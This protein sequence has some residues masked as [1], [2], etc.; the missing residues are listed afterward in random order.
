L[1]CSYD[2]FLRGFRRVGLVTKASVA[3]NLIATAV[4]SGLVVA[5]G[6]RGIAWALVAQPFIVLIVAAIAG[7]DYGTYLRASSHAR[8]REAAIRVVRMGIVLTITGFITTGVQLAARV[9]VEH[10]TSLDD[11][12][13]F[14]AA[15]AISVLYLG[16]VL[17][18]MSLD[19]YPR[20]AEIGT[21]RVALRRMV[22]EQAR[23]SLLLAGPAVLGLL[24][25]SRPIITLLYTARFAPTVELLRWQLVG[26]VLK[27]GSWTLSY[28]VLAQ[29]K[30]LAYFV[31]ELSWNVLYLGV[32]AALL[33]SLGVKATA[34]AYAASS[35]GYF[36]VLSVVAHRL[37]G[38]RWSRG[39]VALMVSTTALTAS[40]L[41]SQLYLSGWQAMAVGIALTALFGAFSLYRLAHEV[42]LAGLIRR[43]RG[44]R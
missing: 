11:V 37:A 39:N 7:R 35:A 26:D 40:V 10:E 1:Y 19:Y 36:A 4:G 34:A 41:V 22:N 3:A 31:T 43:R 17:S 5:F 6:D 20:L 38:F 8:T 18:A 24:T 42:G 13:Y 12:G 27:I 30:K 28:L 14:Q 16:F 29:G 15:W 32:L 21:D 25:L 2:G 23:M 9:L 44:S 33:P